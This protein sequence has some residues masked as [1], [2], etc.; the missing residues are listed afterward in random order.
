MKQFLTESCFITEKVAI[1]SQNH[2]E[3]VQHHE[4]QRNL[5]GK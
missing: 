5:E 2:I 1:V 4:I 3:I